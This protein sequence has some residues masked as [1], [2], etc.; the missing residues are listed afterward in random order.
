MEN[1]SNDLKADAKTKLQQYKSNEVKNLFYHDKCD[2]FDYLIAVGCG[3]IA[4][5][6][7]VFLVGKPGDSKLG[8]WTD[9]QV[10]KVVNVFANIC[11]FKKSRYKDP[12]AFLENKF[13][14]NYDQS[15]SD[16][17]NNRFEIWPGNHRMKSLAHSP[18]IVGLFFS[19]L[20]QFTSTSTFVSN[21]QVVI[22]TTDE[23]ELQ[24]GDFISKIFCGFVNWLG[25]IM[26]DVAG[27]S[28][29]KGRGSGVVIPFYELLGLCDFGKFN[30]DG[31]SKTLAQ[32]ATTVF[33]RGYDARFG[34]TMSIPVVMCD[35]TIRFCWALRQYFG[36]KRPL[37]ECIPSY[38]HDDLRLMLIIGD[39]VLCLMDGADAAIRSKGNWI[40]FFLRFN[41]IAWYRLVLLSAKEVCIRLGINSSMDKQLDMYIRINDAVKQYGEELQCLDVD[42]FR[43][44]TSYFN[45]L[46]AELIQAD[47]EEKLNVLLTK[48]LRDLQVDMPWGESF[49]A[50]VNSDKPTLTIK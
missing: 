21:G 30:A 49:E 11:G 34:L 35:L 38:R 42:R 5:M 45:S 43:K 7:D 13:H 29:S 28:K 2:K 31:E 19:I 12:I 44:E 40:E 4:G 6:V 9:K 41:I 26:A 32:I 8:A 27:T 17:V 16:K 37:R 14:V 46:S 36:Y 15:T 39:G 1:T 23:F 20:N 10:E 25:H 18:D 48:H 3:A 24:G 33:E 22:I 47:T 50:F